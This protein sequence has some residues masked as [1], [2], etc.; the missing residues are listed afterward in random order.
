MAKESFS[1]STII[2]CLTNYRQEAT[3]ARQER[4]DQNKINFDSYHLRQDW[5]YKV[6]G[7][8]REF[9]P[10]QSMAVEQASNFLQQGLSD[11]GDWFRVDAMPGLKEDVMKVKPSTVYKLL[12]LHLQKTGFMRKVGSA[13]KLGLLGSLIIAKVGGRYANKPKFKVKS[14]ILKNGSFKKSLVKMTDKAWELDISLV[15]QQ[16]YY[17][18]PT[19]RGLYEMEDIYM[20]YWEVEKLA[21]GPD[22]I[23]DLEVV[24]QLKGQ[25]D[26]QGINQDVE[27]SRETGLDMTSRGYRR[28]IKLTEIW[29]NILNEEGELIHEN[30]VCTIA[31]DQFVIQKPTENPNWHGE[32]P[33]V[34]CPI[35]DVPHSVWGKA[36]MDAPS[37]L[38]R[39]Y[40]ELF[41]LSLDGGLMSVHGIK[42]LRK[43]WLEDPSQVDDGIPAGTTLIA[44][45]ACPPGQTVLER[46]DTSTVPADG[47][48]VMNLVNQ[49]FNVAALTN[50]LRM[51]VAS[52]RQVKATEV[53]EASQTITSMFSGMAK[54]IE[55]DEDSGFITPILQ[56]AWKTIA[57][58]IGDLDTNEVKALLGEKVATELKAMGNE[59]LFAETVQGCKFLTFGISAILNKQKDFTKLTAL[60]QT[61]G[62]SEVLTE[63][64][65][66]KYDLSKFLEE[67]IKSLDITPKQFLS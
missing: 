51:G 60:L 14:E 7:Q 48:N 5:S 45:S 50:D 13:A 9:L 40:N 67:I 47:L 26:S 34:V 35:I 23:Y 1:E 42:Q 29:G 52:F 37:M 65:L 30:V 63:A 36:L 16:D 46:V 38:N 33:Y 15:R 4:M 24:K 21:T 18:D 32:S 55:G 49:E 44:N 64:F 17:P 6:K 58:N 8:S 27:K 25:Y 41:N 28:Q 66:A 54:N 57:Q 11:I 59:E 2:T 10:K 12:N 53:V 56:K 31:N 62:T 43:G 39:A 22:A 19:G 61:V 3:M 20:D